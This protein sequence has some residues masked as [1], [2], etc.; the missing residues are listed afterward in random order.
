PRGGEVRGRRDR[1]GRGR[2]ARARPRLPRPAR[3]PGWERAGRGPP[4]PDPCR[5]DAAPAAPARGRG[6]RRTGQ[7]RGGDGRRRLPQRVRGWEQ[8]G[9]CG[10][11]RAGARP[12]GRGRLARGRA[13][14]GGR[15]MRGR[16]FAWLNLGYRFA[17]HLLRLPVRALRRDRDLQRH[18]GAVL[19]EGYVPLAAD[20]REAFPAFMNCIHC[21]LCSLAC[22]ALAAAPAPAWEEAWTFVAGPSRAIARARL[23]AEGPAAC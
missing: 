9:G 11:R 18:L 4:R 16:A 22:P 21:G 15:R 17:L 12:R 1:G 3:V 6:A 23:V 2:G 19:P 20:E 7:A 8:S 10:D 14:R 5:P 13:G